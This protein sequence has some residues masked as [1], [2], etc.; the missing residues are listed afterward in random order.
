MSEGRIWL[1]KEG[2]EFLLSKIGMTH[3]EDDIE[4]IR[5]DTTTSGK[6]VFDVIRRK[7]RFVI[8]Y[9]LIPNNVYETLLSIYELGDILSLKVERY[10]GRIDTYKVK[11]R[12]FSRRRL[13][14]ALKWFWGNIS[15]ELEEV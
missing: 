9:S 1:G 11:M 8:E 4:I 5:E 14:R 13:I 2:A 3:Y 7:K 15:I 6:L 10:N 12:P